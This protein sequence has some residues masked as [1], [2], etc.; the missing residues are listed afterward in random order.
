MFK[1]YY[2]TFKCYKGLRTLRIHSTVKDMDRLK[3]GIKP[4]LESLWYYN[5]EI[6]HIEEESNISSYP[7]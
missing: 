5:A 7:V 1:G 6:I 3:E 2:V 4:L